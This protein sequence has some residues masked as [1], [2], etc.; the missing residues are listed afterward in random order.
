MKAQQYFVCVCV[1]MWVCVCAC[2]CVCAR[3]RVRVRVRV[4]ARERGCAGV[5]A[6]VGV[7]LVRRGRVCQ[8]GLTHRYTPMFIVHERAESISC[9]Y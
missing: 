3:A 9:E 7:S 6:R 8:E 2:V 4:C 1:C 5:I